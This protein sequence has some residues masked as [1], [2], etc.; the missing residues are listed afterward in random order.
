MA[1]AEL[2]GT[3]AGMSEEPLTDPFLIGA[4]GSKA[5]SCVMPSA[6]W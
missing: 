2:P 3:R 5:D 1:F 6:I 4:A